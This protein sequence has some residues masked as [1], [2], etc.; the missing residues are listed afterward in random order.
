MD[1]LGT[2]VGFAIAIVIWSIAAMAHAGVMTFG[3][4]VSA[5]LGDRRTELH[6]VG[7]RIHGGAVCAGSR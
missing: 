5:L 7:R 2:R 6:R 3:P 4:S 1:R